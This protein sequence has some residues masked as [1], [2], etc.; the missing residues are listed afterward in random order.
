MFWELIKNGGCTASKV[1]FERWDVDAEIARDKT[2][3]E[4]V[5]RCVQ[6]G[7]FVKDLELFDAA[8]FGISSAEAS[9]IDPQQHVLLKCTYLA[10][11]DAGYTKES[12]QGRNI[13]VFVGITAFDNSVMSSN[14]QGFDVYSLNRSD[15]ATSAGRI[16]FLFGLQGLCSAYA[17]ACSS[18][19]VALH[20]AVRCLQC[21]DCECAIVLGVNTIVAGTP[22]AMM[23]SPPQAA[24]TRSMQQL[25]DICEE[26]DVALWCSSA[27]T[28]FWL[29]TIV[30]M[31]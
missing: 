18:S 17:T 11:K 8:F 12:V 6:W 27:W 5:A 23:G 3:S 14:A 30:C 15:Q 28:M 2:M 16:S 20:S 9:A 31:R 29:T 4:H 19:L 1:P 10:L 26:R 25:M 24:A 22:F 13:G 7:S 21:G